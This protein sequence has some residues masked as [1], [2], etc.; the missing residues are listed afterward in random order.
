MQSHTPRLVLWLPGRILDELMLWLPLAGI[1]NTTQ[2][3]FLRLSVCFS[4]LYCVCACRGAAGGVPAA[5]HCK[6]SAACICFRSFLASPDE[7]STLLSSSSILAHADQPDLRVPGIIRR[8]AGAGGRLCA[9]RRQRHC[10]RA[11]GS[12]GASDAASVSA[13]LP[14]GRTLPPSRSSLPARPAWPPR[15]WSC[16][17]GCHRYATVRRPQSSRRQTIESAG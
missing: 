3:L 17:T 11:A 4:R 6:S 9:D 14:R 8:A 15:G 16:C 2:V 10:L 1:L 12:R 5:A 13:L 7:M